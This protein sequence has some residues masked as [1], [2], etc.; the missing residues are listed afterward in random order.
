MLTGYKWN[1]GLIYRYGNLSGWWFIQQYD[2][3]LQSEYGVPRLYNCQIV[4]SAGSTSTIQAFI[5]QSR[6]MAHWDFE[7]DVID[8]AAKLPAG[9][10]VTVGTT[11]GSSELTSQVVVSIPQ[12][13]SSMAPP[14]CIAACGL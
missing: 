11:G 5:F 1:T 4:N 10:T 9:Q 8:V 6:S 13:C 2:D 7:D 14:V 12:R 3:G